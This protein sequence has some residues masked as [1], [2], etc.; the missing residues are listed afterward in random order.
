M[1]SSSSPSKSPSH[2]R[3]P[4]SSSTT[5]TTS[6]GSSSSSK[7][8]SSLPARFLQLLCGVELIVTIGYYIYGIISGTT[9]QSYVDQ[10]LSFV[11]SLYASLFAGICCIVACYSIEYGVIRTIF[12]QVVYLTLQIICV[13]CFLPKFPAAG[14]QEMKFWL[15]NNCIWVAIASHFLL[16]NA[17]L[18]QTVP[19][20]NSK[21]PA[22]VMHARRYLQVVGGYSIL[23]GLGGLAMGPTQ[24]KTLLNVPSLTVTQE[25]MAELRSIAIAMTGVVLFSLSQAR[26]WIVIQRAILLSTVCSVIAAVVVTSE[27][28]PAGFSNPLLAQVTIFSISGLVG[29]FITVIEKD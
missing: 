6:T 25:F 21:E 29:F 16:A 10:R 1:S 5:A 26:L 19:E 15:Y 17:H 24:A 11:Y 27:K 20:M 8:N 14:V 4:K 9:Q 3:I 12:L 23:L 22:R 28:P 13:L 18:L 7:I 2:R